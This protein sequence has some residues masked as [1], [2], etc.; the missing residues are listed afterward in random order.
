MC[1]LSYEVC[2][3]DTTNRMGS[4]LL[5]ISIMTTVDLTATLIYIYTY[6]YIYA[7]TQQTA[8][9]NVPIPNLRIRV[10]LFIDER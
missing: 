2:K 9:Y 10:S 7:I 1:T 8:W 6:A 4:V 3:T 5:S